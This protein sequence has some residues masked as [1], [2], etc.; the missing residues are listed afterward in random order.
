MRIDFTSVIGQKPIIAILRGMEWD[1]ARP[2]AY[3]VWKARVG[4]VEI[5]LQSDASERLFVRLAELA[6]EMGEVVGA[7]TVISRDG[8]VRAR[9]LGAAF[10][11]SPGF[12]PDVM[13]SSLDLGMPHLPGVA[14]PSEVQAAM[15][16]GATW[17]K[18]FPADAL[19]PEWFTALAGPFPEASF[20]AT[21]GIDSRNAAAFIEAGARAL[22]VGSSLGRP[23]EIGRLTAAIAGADR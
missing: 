3:D 12:D 18:V 19:G 6:S 20:V 1:V 10:T 13:K 2:I 11:I 4:I 16:L 8:V 23:G 9:Q 5:P 15:N 22:G 21:G 7:G 14:T 17:M